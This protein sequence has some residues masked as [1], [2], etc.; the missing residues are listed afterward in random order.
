MLPAHEKSPQILAAMKPRVDALWRAN[1]DVAAS[2]EGRLHR[3]PTAALRDWIVAGT[4]PIRDTARREDAPWLT[5][6]MR[7]AMEAWLFD[8]PHARRLPHLLRR[9]ADRGGLVFA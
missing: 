1:A 5:L 2:L 4:L 8:Q 9:A 6:K 7:E 3:H